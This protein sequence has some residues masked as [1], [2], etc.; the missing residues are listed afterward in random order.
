MRRPTNATSVD[1]HGGKTAGGPAARDE[2]PDPCPLP[3]LERIKAA[4]PAYRLGEKQG[5]LALRVSQL[6]AAADGADPARSKRLSK[7]FVP[8]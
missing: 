8:I 5:Q 6:P 3:F 2:R 4:R 1:N 7:G